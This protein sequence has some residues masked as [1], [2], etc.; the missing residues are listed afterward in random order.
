MFGLTKKQEER[1]LT[2]LEKATVIDSLQYIPVV[3]DEDYFRVMRKAGITASHITVSE[4]SDNFSQALKKLLDW[5]CLVE[6]KESV[7]AIATV[8]KDIKD[9]KKRGKVAVIMGLQNPKPIED[10]IG[11]LKL[12]YKLGIRVVQLT[13]QNRSLIGDGCCERTNCGLS[14]FGVRVIEEMNKLGSLI[15]LSHCGYRTTMEA[16]DLSKDPVAFTHAGLYSFCRN[17]RN[18]SDEQIKALAGKGGVIGMLTWSRLCEVKDGV[19]PTVEYYLD[20]VDYVV[21][22]V[23]IDHV[24]IGTDFEPMWTREDFDKFRF[25]FPELCGKYE[26]DTKSIEGFSHI[27]CLPNV[28]RGLVARGYSDLEILK[29]LGLNFLK[30]F[31][32]VWRE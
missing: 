8:T 10:D 27:S 19:R 4:L 31:K 29:I 6:R 16:I 9:A 21:K 28:T 13:Y 2:L 14:K 7:L 20:F 25:D 32:R 11:L 26:F 5:H 18:K 24:G 23:G 30:L 1:A 3:K 15:D 17:P 12:F 22:L